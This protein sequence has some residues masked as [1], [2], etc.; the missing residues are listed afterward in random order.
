MLRPY[1]S[2]SKGVNLLMLENGGGFFASRGFRLAGTGVNDLGIMQPDRF[3][4]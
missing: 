2:R 4:L 1:F 3:L